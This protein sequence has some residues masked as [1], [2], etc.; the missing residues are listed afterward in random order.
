M[1]KKLHQNPKTI[2]NITLGGNEVETGNKLARLATLVDQGNEDKLEKLMELLDTEEDI[3]QYKPYVEKAAK[4]SILKAQY[5]MAREMGP[6]SLLKL[7]IMKK[8][9]EQNIMDSVEQYKLANKN[10]KKSIFFLVISNIVIVAVMI[11]VLYRMAIN[12]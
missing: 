4:K 1:G 11:Y 8:A 6:F 5:I 10:F 7:S 3:A 2:G 12:G 9:A